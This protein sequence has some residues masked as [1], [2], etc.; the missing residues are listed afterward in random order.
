MGK[1]EE[2]T[3]LNGEAFKIAEKAKHRGTLFKYRLLQA[4]IKGATDRE[5]ATVQLKALLTRN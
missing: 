3:K 4:K 2:P 1:T 5:S